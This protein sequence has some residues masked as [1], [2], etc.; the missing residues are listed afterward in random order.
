MSD[1]K[2]QL[3]I[4][5]GVVKRLNKELQMYVKEVE[6]GEKK[7]QQMKDEGKDP[8]DIKKMVSV[9]SW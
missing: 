7:V 8:Y 5:S 1:A 3:R 2:K 9:L 4:K 6:D